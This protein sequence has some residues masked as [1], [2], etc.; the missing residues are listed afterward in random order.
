VEASPKLLASGL[1]AAGAAFAAQLDINWNWTRFLLFDVGA[2]GKAR[3]SA[4]LA[5]VT[6]TKRDY[7]ELASKRDF[8]YLVRL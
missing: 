8:F 4:A 7:V 3:V 6:H 2:D 1:R 5:E